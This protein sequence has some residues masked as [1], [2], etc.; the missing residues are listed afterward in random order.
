MGIIF[1]GLNISKLIEKRNDKVS[2]SLLWIL[3]VSGI[4]FSRVAQSSFLNGDNFISKL[5]Y[6]G[7]ILIFIGYLLWFYINKNL[8]VNSS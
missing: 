3:F 6:F 5:F 1:I 4:L 2:F 8:K 7:S